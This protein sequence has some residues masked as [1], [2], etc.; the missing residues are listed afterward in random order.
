MESGTPGVKATPDG[1]LNRALQAEDLRRPA[2]HTAFR[3]VALGSQVPR[4]LEGKISAVAV[5][6]VQT[7]R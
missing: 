1:W 2:T 4:T 3:A 5:N 7:S 6:R